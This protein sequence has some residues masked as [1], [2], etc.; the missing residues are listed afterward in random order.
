[1]NTAEISRELM[2]TLSDLNRQIESIKTQ[3]LQDRIPAEDVINEKGERV[4]LP[5]VVAKAHVLHAIVMN[6]AAK[7]GL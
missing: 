7:K 5:L 4:L 1:M 2:R 6:N 3:A